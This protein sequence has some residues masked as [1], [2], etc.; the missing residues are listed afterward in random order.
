M[1]NV[2][3]W[4]YLVLDNIFWANTHQPKAGGANFSHDGYISSSADTVITGSQPPS[5]D[6]LAKFLK[7]A[8]DEGWEMC[9]YFQQEWGDDL[10]Y[11]YIF[12]RPIQE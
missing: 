1:G 12:K 11:R 7:S 9:G 2:Q 4:E 6:E 3:R 10:T 5:G 8:G